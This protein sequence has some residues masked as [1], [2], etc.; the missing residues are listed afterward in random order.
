[1]G[2]SQAVAKRQ[3]WLSAHACGTLISQAWFSPCLSPVQLKALPRSVTLFSECSV[4][5]AI[6]LIF[7][8]KKYLPVFVLLQTELVAIQGSCRPRSPFT[9]TLGVFFSSFLH[10]WVFTSSSFLGY[11]F[12]FLKNFFGRSLLY[13]I[14]LV[15]AIHQQESAT[16]I[17]AL[18]LEPP[19]HLQPFATL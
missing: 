16:Y 7:L 13:Y 12:S 10:L 5:L 2:H 4:T 9:I 15:S 17:C 19:S 18:P 6:L 8:L 1:M 11:S 3:T 14:V